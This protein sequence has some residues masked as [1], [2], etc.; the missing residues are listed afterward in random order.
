MLVS[1]ATT[2]R[3]T[4]FALTLGEVVRLGL[5]VAV[6]SSAA[7]SLV[8]MAA[9][10]VQVGV[11][12]VLATAALAAAAL[13]VLLRPRASIVEP[14]W[15][16]ILAVAVGVTGKAWFLLLGPPD[17]VEFLLLGRTLPELIPAAAITAAGMLCLAVAYAAGQ[18]RWRVPVPGRPAFDNWSDR[19][20][21]IVAAVF[22]IV[23]C[24]SFVLF[25]QQ[26]DVSSTDLR[27]FSLPRL[28]A[29]EGS[30]YA[31]ASGY[32]RWGAM[33]VETAFYIVFA[34][35]ASARSRHQILFGVCALGL[36]GLAV[37][38]P[39]FS[40]TRRPIVFL[41]FR[42]V[43]VWTCLRGEPRTRHALGLAALGLLLATSMIAVRTGAADWTSFRSRMGVDDVLNVTVGSRHFLDLTKTAHILEAFPGKLPYRHGTSLITWL[44]AP[45]PRALWPGKPAIGIGK[46]LGP[47]VFQS[48]SGSGVP[49]GIIGELYL[50]FGLPGVFV[51]LPLFGALLRSLYVTASEYFPGKGAVVV[52]AVISTHVGF[53]A[54]TFD[55]SGTIAKLLQELIPLVAAIYVCAHVGPQKQRSD[56]GDRLR[57]QLP[58]PLANAPERHHL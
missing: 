55:V 47:V 22:A 20:V 40:S 14:I 29:I 46:E 21:A 49:P 5:A 30:T 24:V 18:F 58:T 38:F 23:G 12:C 51:A 13:P 9:H 8:V 34:H 39:V 32:L 16:V 1:V 4:R 19:T 6:V 57:A 27:S 17:R 28:V 52:Y 25:A 48:R 7:A 15:Y 11:L 2:K 33:L 45:V 41:V 42:I 36:L 31:G 43:V 44:V 3:S 50:N 54:V 37:A 53:G 35:W 26:F 56:S 10:D